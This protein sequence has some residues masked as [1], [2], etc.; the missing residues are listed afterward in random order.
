MGV[1][2]KGPWKAPGTNSKFV[3]IRRMIDHE[4]EIV[5]RL[6]GQMK[7]EAPP[8]QSSTGIKR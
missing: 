2:I 1:V 8:T 7:Q 6:A 5:D 3:D 4:L